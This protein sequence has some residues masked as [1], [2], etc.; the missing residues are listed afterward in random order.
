M[1][2]QLGPGDR[3]DPQCRT[4][5]KR[6]GSKKRQDASAFFN[7]D[8]DVLNTLG[9]LTSARGGG[10]E[11]RKAEGR[12]APLSPAERVEAAFRALVRRVAEQA[13]YNG[14]PPD[15]LTMA[16]L[17]KLTPWRSPRSDLACRQNAVMIGSWRAAS[18]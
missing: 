8:L 11:G 1:R 4:S 18:G 16:N 17:P 9:E 15:A 3:H 14:P 13:C 10:E 2:E 12:L 6:P 5:G 7:V